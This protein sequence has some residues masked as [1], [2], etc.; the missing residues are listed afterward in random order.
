M[1]D[2]S[3]PFGKYNYNRGSLINSRVVNEKDL[4]IV[5]ERTIRDF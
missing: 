4:E 5:R 2:L 3:L 1:R